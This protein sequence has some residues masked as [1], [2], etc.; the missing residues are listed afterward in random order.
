VVLQSKL[1]YQWREPRAPK[2]Y[3]AAV[4][5]HGHTNRSKE[6]LSFISEYASRRPVLRLALATQERRAQT[7]SA[8]TVDFSKAYWTPP[9]S[10]FAAFLLERDQIERGL[11]IASMVS[12]TDHDNIEAPLSLRVMEETAGIPISVEWSVP[13]QNTTLHL[14]VHNLPADH[15]EAIMIQLAAYTKD[16]LEECLFD[17]LRTLHKN[18]DVLIVLNHPMWDLAGIGRQHHVQTLTDFVAKFGNHIHA[19][20]LC[21]MRHWEEN[22]AVLDFAEKWNQVV[23]GGGDRHGVEPSAVVNLTSAETFPEFVQEVRK[24][25]RSHVLFMP[26]YAEPFA[27]RILQ[28]LLDVVREYPDLPAGFRRWDERV[29]HPDRNGILRPLSTLWDAPPVFIPCFFSLVRM[30]EIASVRKAVQFAMAKPQ[31]EMSFALGKGQ[32]A[33]SQWKKIYGSLFSRTPMTKSMAWQT[34]AANLRRSR[35]SAGSTS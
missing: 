20:E 29:F 3:R 14:G 23:V 11:G 2:E 16:P 17:L 25:R 7:E 27:L 12:L 10:P 1:S 21:G 4:S 18:P 6:G 24:K 26:Q 33:A 15:A 35:R 31:H 34:P 32:E 8:I 13:Y 22:R 9:L 5:L 28:S 19:F 30:L